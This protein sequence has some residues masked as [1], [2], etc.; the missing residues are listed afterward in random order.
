MITGDDNLSQG[1]TASLRFAIGK[2]HHKQED[3]ALARTSEHFGQYTPNTPYIDGL[4]TGVRSR[5][6]QM[7]GEGP[8]TLE[9][10]LNVNIT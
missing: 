9:Y 7:I 6:V 5:H 3:A 1:T 8:G 4:R 10:S 2:R